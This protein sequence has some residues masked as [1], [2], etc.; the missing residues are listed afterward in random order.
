[1]AIFTFIYLFGTDLREVNHDNFMDKGV[2][3]HHSKKTYRGSGGESPRIIL[4]RRASAILPAA[5]RLK[6]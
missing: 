5:R 6:N 2:A 1:V 3:V 4:P